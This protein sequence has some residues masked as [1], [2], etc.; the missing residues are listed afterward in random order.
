MG[1]IKK[2]IV[3]Q[4]QCVKNLVFQNLFFEIGQ[5][6]QEGMDEMY[7]MDPNLH[8]Q[9]ARALIVFCFLR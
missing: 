8:T 5:R 3:F 1:P 9:L 4:I 7:E 2:Q 6:I